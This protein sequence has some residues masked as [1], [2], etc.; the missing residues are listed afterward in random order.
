MTSRDSCARM[1]KMV[2]ALRPGGIQWGSRQARWIIAATVGASA[3]AMLDTTAVNVALPAIGSEVQ[4]GVGGLQWIVSGYTLSLASLILLSGALADR[5]GRRLIFQVGIAW[6]AVASLMC[7]LAPTLEVLIAARVLQGVGG[8]LL[9]PGSLAIIQVSFARGDRGRAIGTWSGLGGVAAAVGPL[10]GGWLV[11]AGSWRAVFWINLPVAAVVLWIA[12]RHVPESRAEVGEAVHFDILGAVLGALGLGAAT[13]ALIAA[14]D[15]GASLAVIAAA[16]AGIAGLGAFVVVEHGARAPL[17][18]L[19]LFES[20]QFSGVNLVTFVV[21]GGMSVL[22]FLLV[23]YLQNVA[24]YSPILAGTAL[25]PVTLL[26][27]MLSAGAGALAERIGPRRLMTIGP[28]AMAVGMLLLS[29]IGEKVSYAAHV[30]P[31]VIVFGLGLSATVA[32]L[33]ATVLA[34]VEPRNA[35]IASGVNNAVARTASLL[36]VAV[37]PVVSG[38]TGDAFRDA[39]RFHQGFGTAMTLGAALMVV[40]AALAWIVI[41]D[42]SATGKPACD[43]RQVSRHTFCAIDGP[44]LETGSR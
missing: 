24:G 5:F 31:G 7:S 28:L 3:M 40:G 13:W 16:A 38:L 9:T 8:A 1:M 18:P 2:E 11:E 25:I 19:G 14:G 22:F 42:K 43:Q 44:P 30:L 32:P 29:R 26:M 10:L 20:R 36:G 15:R 37:L 33:T 23:V 4:A 27:L 12:A 21:Y 34:A 41:R 17:V 35:G 6:F 39:M